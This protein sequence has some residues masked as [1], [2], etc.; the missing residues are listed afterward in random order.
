MF[1]C[2][3]DVEDGPHT[4]YTASSI[5]YLIEIVAVMLSYYCFVNILKILQS[6]SCCMNLAR[7]LQNSL[8]KCIPKCHALTK[9]VSMSM[10]NGD[11]D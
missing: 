1:V 6:S 8:I 2:C 9:W 3:L 5:L 11:P 4:I 7:I 10:V